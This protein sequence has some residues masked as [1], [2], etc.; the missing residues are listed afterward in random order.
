MVMQE[1][2]ERIVIELGSKMVT[3]KLLPFDTEID[4][5]SIIQIDY[6]NI[7]G[8]IL[9]FGVLFNRIANLKAEI[10]SIIK[11]SRFDLEV[12]MA[13][14]K[15]EKRSKILSEGL[16]ATVDA[17]ES[18][19]IQDEEYIGKKRSLIGLEKDGQYLDNLYWNCQSKSQLLQRLS[20][21][22]RPEEFSGEILSETLNGVMIKTS[23]KVIQ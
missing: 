5:E 23:K 18:Q 10:D 2:E 8:E 20:D 11:N 22:V 21:K 1:E 4:V 16:K 17:I 19:V 12:F 3:L 9:T 14:L 13:K 6:S 15:E 7:L